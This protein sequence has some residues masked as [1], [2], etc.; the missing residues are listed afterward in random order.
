LPGYKTRR[1][2]GQWQE[3]NGMKPTCFPEAAM[4]GKLR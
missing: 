2:I 1:S 4:K 3:K